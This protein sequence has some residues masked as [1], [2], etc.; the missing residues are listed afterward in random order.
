ML[1]KAGMIRSKCLDTD[2]FRARQKAR[3]ARGR[4]LK[5]PC[6]SG[7]ISPGVGIY[8]QRGQVWLLQPGNA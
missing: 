5:E 4:L 3:V 7:S 8:P 2:S 1:C 6:G